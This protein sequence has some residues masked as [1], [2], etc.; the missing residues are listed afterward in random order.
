MNGEVNYAKI[1]KKYELKRLGGKLLSKSATKF[2]FS[3]R[4]IDYKKLIKTVKDLDCKVKMKC[5]ENMKEFIAPLVE[6]KNLYDHLNNSKLADSM[7]IC[8]PQDKDT[9]NRGIEILKKMKAKIKQSQKCRNKANFEDYCVKMDQLSKLNSEY[10][11]VIPKVNPEMIQAMLYEHEINNEIDLLQSVFSLSFQIRIVLGA[12][13][14]VTKVNPYDYIFGSLPVGLEPVKSGSDE[15]ELI[16]H[17]LN[18]SKNNNCYLANLIKISGLEY[19]AEED[20]KFLSTDNH[21][22]LWH[23]S[24]GKNV[25]GIIKN[26][27]KIKPTETS[28]TGSRFGDGIYFSDSFELSNCFSAGEGG[29]DRYIML[30]EVALGN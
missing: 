3:N 25:L 5:S 8:S 24:P 23:G 16:L 6:D 13:Y 29:K 1:P 15:E 28:F 7:L 14:N 12:Y 20:K 21:V 17:Y 2:K 4:D 26:G 22:M 10:L 30:C 27:L 11:E 18:T 19:K 9:L